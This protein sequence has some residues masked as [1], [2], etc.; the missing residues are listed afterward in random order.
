MIEFHSEGVE[1]SLKKLKTTVKGLTQEEASKRLKKDG[2]NKLPREKPISKLKIFLTQF[3]NPLA[4]IL[5]A[6]G[7]I[8]LLL[9]E[10]IDS[11]VIFTAILLNT[12]I[13]YI[14]ENKASQ[15]MTKLNNLVEF[16]S[17]VLRD[18][19]EQSI[20]SKDLV[21]GDIILLK[22]GNKIPADARVIDSS[23]LRVNESSIT[24]ESFPVNKK[25]DQVYK[26]GVVLADRKNM[27]Y[28]GTIVSHGVGRAVIVATGINTEIGKIAQMVQSAVEEETPLQK[29]LGSFS[30]LL[31][32]LAAFICTFIVVIGISQGRHFFE[33]FEIGVAIA[34][35]S[36]PEGLTVA[37]TFIL[38]LGMQKIL[39]KKALTKKLVAAETLGS[40]TTICTDKTGT[41]TEGKMHVD[42]I[43]IGC[44]EFSV[45][46]PGSRQDNKEAKIVSLALQ[47]AMMCNDAA[48]ENPDDALST[49][50][51]I[52]SSTEKA[53]LKAA[54]QSGLR[55]KEVLKNEP[56]VA[57]E[58]AFSLS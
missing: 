2:L 13:G 33:M 20:L 48:V 21:V 26:K 28:A 14:Q 19:N 6:A 34:V 31:G 23:D 45:D 47:T 57:G 11:G 50:R 10:Y 44:N 3:N 39:K 4:Y 55:K 22:S 24:G 32:I 52:G 5:I 54:I 9:H 36:I 51:F 41:L 18:G 12:V 56:F 25:F 27:V 49:W 43:V 16:N 58:G 1:E 29:R 42:H 38:A 35:A 40:I 53:L 46:F 37:V 7:S 30:K 15:A 8:S 17:F